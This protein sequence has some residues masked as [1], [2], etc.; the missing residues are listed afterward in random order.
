MKSKF[1]KKITAI[2]TAAALVLTMAATAAVANEPAEEI[3][4][5][6]SNHLEEVSSR[7]NYEFTLDRPGRIMVT[8]EG[9]EFLEGHSSNIGWQFSVF[10]SNDA[11]LI[12][13]VSTEGSRNRI[14]P[15]ASST[16]RYLPAGTYS[17]VV[18]STSSS[19]FTDSPYRLTV[20]YTENTGQFEIEANNT[21]QWANPMSTDSPISGNIWYRNDVDYFE[22]TVTERG[23][24]VIDFSRRLVQSDRNYWRV[25]LLDIDQKGLEQFDAN[26]NNDRDITSPIELTAGT[27]FVR[28]SV[29][30]NNGTTSFRTTEYTLT[31]VHSDTIP[32]PKCLGCGRDVHTPF[33]DNCGT[34]AGE[35]PI[36]EDC[37]TCVLHMLAQGGTP[38]VQDALQILRFLV[39]LPNRID[40]TQ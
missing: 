28:V 15:A 23:W 38:T 21:A 14:P 2:I 11:R 34:K 12:N 19:R 13:E 20:S 39:G 22:L 16:Y 31:V 3:I 35:E 33:C 6:E 40:G 37:T 36:A 5:E 32:A 7:N 4:F 17:I 27:Y 1:R 30:P 24:Y 9:T 25:Q 8:I 10:D 18:A 26:G 29:P